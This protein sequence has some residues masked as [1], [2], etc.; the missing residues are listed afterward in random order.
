MTGQVADFESSGNC[1]HCGLCVASCPTFLELG[2]EMDSPRGRIQLMRSIDQGTIPLDDAS[3]RHLDLCL[4]CRACE[5]TCP[6]GVRYGALIEGA[7]HFI[8][9][10]HR[11]PW[12]ERAKRWLVNR[13]FPNPAI[14]RLFGRTVQWLTWLGIGGLAHSRLLPASVRG[15][16]RYLPDRDAG[17]RSVRLP[18]RTA[19]QGEV[20]H[21]VGL[22]AGCVMQSLFGDTHTNTV[23]LLARHGCEVRVPLDAGCCGAL[24]LHNGDR[25]RGLE[26][27]R[28]A[29]AAFDSPELD[30]VLTNAAGCGAAMREYGE[31]FKDDAVLGPAAKRVADKVR[32]VA[33]FVHGLPDFEPKRSLDA[34]VAYHDACHLLNGQGV[35]AQPRRLL[36]GIPGVELVE[37][38][39]AE[40]CCGSAGSYNLTETELAGRLAAR[41]ARNVMET[42]A[43]VLVTGN[44]GCILQIRAALREQG[45]SIRV[46]HTVDFLAEA[47]TNRAAARG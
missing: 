28:A 17:F 33:E 22:L 1:I 10:R 31:H 2:T 16:L 9:S 43:D 6:S 47:Y 4:G 41:K 30:A 14:M 38:H 24:L 15:L 7:R 42:G 5:T 13:T 36:A 18:E 25:E 11:R 35:Q 3:V 39:E 20:R 37:L 27:A 21:R 34:R 26:L 46:V 19:A 44:P 32:D 45:S 23:Q 40:V 29:I 12:P 8:E